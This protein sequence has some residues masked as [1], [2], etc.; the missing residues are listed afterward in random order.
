MP[1]ERKQPDRGQQVPHSWSLNG[2][3]ESVYPN[4][5][6]KGRY[7]VREN[8]R[9]LL[10]ARALVRI[11]RELVVIG[12]PYLR[13]MRGKAR[14]VAGYEIAPNRLNSEGTTRTFAE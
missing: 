11:G 7:L 4:E 1:R 12:E 2:W 10:E 14:E 3:P 13:W 8:R 6:G 5:P 9:E